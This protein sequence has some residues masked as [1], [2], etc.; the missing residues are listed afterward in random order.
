MEG[1]RETQEGGASPSPTKVGETWPALPRSGQAGSRRYRLL[2]AGLEVDF[3]LDGVFFPVGAL[4]NAAAGFDHAG[5]AAEIG[6]GVF[7]AKV[8]DFDVFADEVVDA[9]DFATP[10][11]IF[12]GTAD[13]GNVFQPGSFVGDFL[14]FVAV[15]EFMGEAGTLDAKETMLSGHG[16]AALLPILINRADIADV[17]RDTG[18]GGKQ[19]MIFAAAAKIERE[20]AFGE[21]A[22]KQRGADMHGVEEGRKFAVG[23]AFDEEFQGGFIGGGADGVGALDALVTF[24]FD[25]EGGVLSGKKGKRSAGIDFQDE[26]VF[27]DVA[28][29]EDF[30]GMEFFRIG[31]QERPPES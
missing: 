8:P 24:E 1:R 27:G 22:K 3:V 19:E 5:V 29:I 20:A 18:D 23:D 17:R 21:A 13:G 16:R 25:A 10:V 7:G 26:E 30:C 9:A 14:K 28:T 15:A 6:G 11:G 4:E 31:D 12:P 2:G